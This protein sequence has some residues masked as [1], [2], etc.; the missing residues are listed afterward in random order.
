M[1][2]IMT[3]SLDRE[4]IRVVG[5]QYKHIQRKHTILPPYE[6]LE[7]HASDMETEVAVSIG[8]SPQFGMYLRTPIREYYEELREVVNKR[9]SSRSNPRR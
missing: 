4:I 7:E 1:I 3:W 6:Q 2:F 9:R 5:G 8:M